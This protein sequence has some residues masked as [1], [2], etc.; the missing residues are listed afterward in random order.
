MLLFNQD[1][2]R[3]SAPVRIGSALLDRRGPR[4]TGRS[5]NESGQPVFRISGLTTGLGSNSDERLKRR[6][7]LSV[8][9]A[10]DVVDAWLQ[11]GRPKA[12]RPPGRDGAGK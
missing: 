1:L 10:F 3:E 8:E 11:P 2:P 5:T 6:S 9:A 7:S 12:T 4:R